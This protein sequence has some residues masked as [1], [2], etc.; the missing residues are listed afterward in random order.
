MWSPQA[1]PRLR[2]EAQHI[3][4]T[5]QRIELPV[6]PDFQNEYMAAM[7]FPHMDH[8]FKAL[9]GLIPDHGPD[10]LADRLRGSSQA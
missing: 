8:K 9:E 6:D 7:N 1:P 4:R 5:I 10:P 3:A 2:L